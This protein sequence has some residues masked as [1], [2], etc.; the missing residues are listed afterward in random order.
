[1]AERTK[2]K[3]KYCGKQ[4]TSGYMSKHLQSCAARRKHLEAGRETPRQDEAGYFLIKIYGAYAKEYWLYIE[5]DEDLTLADLDQFLRDIWV[6][7]CGHLSEFTIHG[8]RFPNIAYDHWGDDEDS[9]MATV[10]LGDVLRPGLLMHYEYDFGSTTYLDLLVE[11]YRQGAPEEEPIIIL[12]RNI[13]PKIMCE[14]CKKE[15]AT[16]LRMVFNPDEEC[17]FCDE[18]SE[19]LGLDDEELLLVCNSPRMGTCGY[20][21]SEMYPEEFVPDTELSD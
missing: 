18:C 3:C 7:C 19:K 4:Y 10:R 8:I 6:E 9:E 11:D 20:C 1:M 17:F 13:A 15:E 14:H 12:S 5:A 16:V 21:G 2:G